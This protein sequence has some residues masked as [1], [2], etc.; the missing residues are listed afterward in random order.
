M[1]LTDM[2]CRKAAPKDRVY[3]ISDGNGLSLRIKPN[4]SKSWL[5]RY[6]YD[7]KPKTISLGQ[8]PLISLQEARSKREDSRKTVSEGKNPSVIRKIEKA[9]T[10]ASTN[11]TFKDY[12]KDWLKVKGADLDDKTIRAHKSKL[13]HHIYPEIA[14]LPA[15]AVTTPI[16]ANLLRKIE[17]KGLGDTTDRCASL[18]RRIYAF[19]RA[20][21]L[22]VPN[23][24]SDVKEVL[25]EVAR[26]HFAAI[27]P[28]ETG[29]LVA[30]IE[31]F[32]K[33][34]RMS[35]QTYLA[36]YIL[37]NTWL[38]TF[39]LIAIEW[40]F[41]DYEKE[42]LTVPMVN[43]KG[44]KRA[45]KK[46]KPHE[47]PTPHVISLTKQAIECFKTLRQIGSSERFVFPH[48]RNNDKHM[49]DSTIL[50]ALYKMGY[51][52]RMTGHGFRTLGMGVCKEILKYRH[53]LPDRQLAHKPKNEVDRAYD[54]AMFFQ[55]R[56]CM[57]QQFAD[58]ID[59]QK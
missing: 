37:L 19:A 59:T 57:M 21:G 28:S 8:Y 18:I 49:S 11:M 35:Y 46:L 55:D 7:G 4:G 12:A 26:G 13:K 32:W 53:E 56:K 22:N 23:P 51:K 2:K 40:S 44:G 16:V 27:E 1:H 36:I 42:E 45:A 29:E 6:R 31:A 48:E 17:D 47:K 34:R 30:D 10:T 58:Y 5:F 9:Q 38:R 43:M 24:A 50:R 33:A 3:T 25:K 41:I 20:G 39:E 54:R 15:E 14:A 52:G